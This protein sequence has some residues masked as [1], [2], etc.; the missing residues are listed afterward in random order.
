MMDHENEQHETVLFAV[1]AIIITII[2]VITNLIPAQVI[3]F[4]SYDPYHQ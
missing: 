2:N 3:V 4:F 1:H